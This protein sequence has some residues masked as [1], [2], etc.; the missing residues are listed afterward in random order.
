MDTQLEDVLQ[1]TERYPN[2][3]VGLAG[4][5]LFRIKES[6]KEIELAVTKHDFKGVYVHIGN[7]IVKPW[8]R[9]QLQFGQGSGCLIDHPHISSIECQVSRIITC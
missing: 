1:Y 3:F 2:R 7:K 6:L 4:Y 8:R 9:R 5:N